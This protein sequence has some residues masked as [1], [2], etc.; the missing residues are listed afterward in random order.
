MDGKPQSPGRG[1]HWPCVQL[2]MKPDPLPP[3]V[4]HSVSPYLCLSTYE[5]LSTLHHLPFFVSLTLP[6]SGSADLSVFLSLLSFSTS[7]TLF[8]CFSLPRLSP[9]LTPVPYLWVSGSLASFPYLQHKQHLG[10]RSSWAQ[11]VQGGHSG[12]SREAD[13]WGWGFKL[14]QCPH[15]GV[16][17]TL[18]ML[19][20]ETAERAIPGACAPGSGD[21]LGGRGGA[22]SCHEEPEQVQGPKPHI[23]GSHQ[24][25]CPKPGQAPHTW[26]FNPAPLPPPLRSK[27]SRPRPSPL[28]T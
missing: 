15:L 10:N 14:L 21:G 8:L 25:P 5:S 7:L 9:S 13:L 16:G 18:T 28:S 19:R 26:N 3:S 24:S 4:I 20:K 17:T 2:H 27:D 12:G 11:A 1:Q 6:I 23:C 22:R